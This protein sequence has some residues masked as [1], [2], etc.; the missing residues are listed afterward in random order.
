MV[1]YIYIQFNN[2][3]KSFGTFFLEVE[4]TLPQNSIP[5]PIRSFT[6]KDE[7][8]VNQAV[9]NGQTEGHPVSE[10]QTLFLRNKQSKL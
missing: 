3:T 10:V 7:N 6:V 9:C 2:E 5:G 4:G 8:H 1:G